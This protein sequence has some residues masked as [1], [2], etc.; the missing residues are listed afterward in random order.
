MYGVNGVAGSIRTQALLLKYI[1]AY[2]HKHQ[3]CHKSR[4]ETLYANLRSLALGIRINPEDAVLNVD[5]LALFL[6]VVKGGALL[7]PNVCRG[8]GADIVIHGTAVAPL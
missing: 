2:C 1:F 3:Q 7:V 8:D 5:P 4:Y 6:L